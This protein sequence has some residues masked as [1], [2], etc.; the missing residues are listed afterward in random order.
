MRKLDW[1]ILKKFFVTFFFCLFLFTVIAVAVDSSEKTDNFVKSGLTTVQLI[2]QYYL[3]FV[4]WIWSLLFP[5]FVFI[6]VIFFTSRMALRSEIIAMLAS[7]VTYNRILRPYFIGGTILAIM[8]WYGNRYFIPKANVIRSNFQ[9]NYVDK[10]DPTLNRSFVSCFNCYYLRTDSNTFVGI[11][12]FDTATKRARGFFMEKV[13]GD[14]I[15][16]NLRSSVIQWDTTNKKWTLYNAVERKVDSMGELIH[17]YDTLPINLSVKPV[18][19]RKDDYLKDKL[20]TPQLVSFIKQEE[21]RGT[22]GLNTL[23]VERYR[24]TATPASVLLLTIIGAIVAGRKTRG[25]SGFH[26][27]IGITM[28]AFFILS[29]RFSTVFSTKADFPPF[30]AVW[31]PNIAFTLIAL[32]LY[33]KAPK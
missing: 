19:L 33:R 11:K 2:R 32:W 23:K 14:K 15:I 16:Y 21:L 25:G 30:I 12:E 4:P 28:A 22:E 20:T 13:R 10:G 1:Y 29:D 8:L 18:E 27:A 17:H 24:R 6:S 3:G 7:G 26:L 31:L 5:L 9:T